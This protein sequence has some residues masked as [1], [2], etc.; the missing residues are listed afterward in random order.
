MNKKNWKKPDQSSSLLET[1]RQLEPYLGI[2]LTFAVSILAFLFLG[3]WLDGVLG[4]Y[5]W[6]MIIGAALGLTLGFIHLITTLNAQ[7]KQES[8][9][10]KVNDGQENGQ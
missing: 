6:L 9:K 1:Y 2:G 8:D 5:P 3:H 10:H 4:T 7:T